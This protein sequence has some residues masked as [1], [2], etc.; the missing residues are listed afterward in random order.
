VKKSRRIRW[1]GHVASIGQTRNTHRIL[2]GKPERK[3]TLQ[4]ARHIWKI[5]SETHLKARLVSLQSK[6][7]QVAGSF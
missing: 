2:L 5:Q 3:R 6:Q 1:A 7:E 4:R